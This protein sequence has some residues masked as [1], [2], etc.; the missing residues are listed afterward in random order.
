MIESEAINTVKLT[1]IY[2]QLEGSNIVNLAYQVNDDNL[3][4]EIFANKED[5]VFYESDNNH[6]I[7]K[8][9]EIAKEYKDDIENFQ[10]LAPMYKT[11]N[12]IDRINNNLQNVFN[13]KNKNKKE[14]MIGNVLFREQDK[15]IQLTNMPDDNVFNGDIGT[16][17][18]I[19]NGTKKEI[20]INF[21]GNRVRYTAS[22]FNKFKHAYA[23]SIHKSQGS[24]FDYVL[25][26]VLPEYNKMLY[27]KL[28]YTGVTRAKKKLYLI[29]SLKSLD[30]AIK[31]NYDNIRKT[32][33]K[34]KLVSNILNV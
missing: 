14:I 21:F 4:I 30:Q 9:M 34:E 18:S 31:N 27:R 25:I 3:D 1:E 6:V 16:I 13:E 26:P 24:E 32:T 11:F 7:D 8:I 23:I 12:G 2:R 19:T 29:G 33:L 20:V 17:E 28:I 22:N 5:L 10:I 15:V